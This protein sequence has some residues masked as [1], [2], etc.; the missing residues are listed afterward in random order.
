M[1]PPDDAELLACY[2]TQR[3]EEAFA[4]LV[5]RHLS[6]VYSSALRQVRDLYRAPSF[7]GLFESFSFFLTVS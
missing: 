2:V 6:L 3:S 1:R 5:E 7:L 4:T